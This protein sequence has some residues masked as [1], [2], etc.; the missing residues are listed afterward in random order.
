MMLATLA[1][2][3]GLSDLCNAYDTLGSRNF[4][5]WLSYVIKINSMQTIWMIFK[6]KYFNVFKDLGQ[7]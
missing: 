2:F 6:N 7:S 3:N 5:K 4:V 1:N